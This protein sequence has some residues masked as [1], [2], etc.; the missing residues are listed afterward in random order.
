MMK[1]NSMI[2]NVMIVVVRVV[3]GESLQHPPSPKYHQNRRD[4]G[5]PERATEP[6]PAT[7]DDTPFSGEGHRLNE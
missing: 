1:F 2:R 5:A 6:Q 4:R 7:T 3:D